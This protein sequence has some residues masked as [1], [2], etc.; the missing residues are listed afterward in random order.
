M[1]ESPPRF[2]WLYDELMSSETLYAA[3]EPRAKGAKWALY[4][5]SLPESDARHVPEN[6]SSGCMS[7]GC[8]RHFGLLGEFYIHTRWLG[9]KAEDQNPRGTAVDAGG[10]S[11]G[12][13]PSMSRR[14]ICVIASRVALNWP[15]RKRPGSLPTGKTRR[16]PLRVDRAWARGRLLGPARGVYRGWGRDGPVCPWA[17]VSPVSQ[18]CRASHRPVRWSPSRLVR[19]RGEDQ[20]VGGMGESAYKVWLSVVLCMLS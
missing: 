20:R 10:C 14:S 2:C 9:R 6:V 4:Q 13:M 5:W 12:L 8:G 3:F 15:K 18:G 16:T 19:V 17:V 1:S 11:A 7:V